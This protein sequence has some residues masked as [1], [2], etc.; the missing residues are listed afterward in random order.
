MTRLYT[1]ATPGSEILNFYARERVIAS[2]LTGERYPPNFEALER[3]PEPAFLFRPGADSLTPTLKVLGASQETEHVGGYDLIR[4]VR[5]M[6]RRYRQVPAAVLRGSASH[7]S[8]A[9]GRA[10]DRD[11]DSAWESVQPRTP[12]MWVEL[13]LGKPVN[14]GMV[15]LWNRGQDHG[16]Y[17]M[18]LRV[19]TS[20]DGTAWRDAVARSAMDYFYSSGP[21][22][23]PWEWGY[24][25]E[26]SFVPVAARRV[27]ISQYEDGGRFPWKIAEAYVYEDLGARPL[28]HT[29]EPD[30]LRRVAELG[31]D[32]VYADR[33]MSARIS[34]SSEGRVE[35]VTPFTAAI[36]AFYVK[37]KSRV[38]RWGERTGFVLEDGDAD[39][40]ERQIRDE[41]VHRLV[42]EDFGRW[43]LFHARG[44]GAAAAALENDPG[45]WW[46][47]LGA[48][49]TDP[50]GKSRYLASL[51]QTAYGDGRFDQAV[52]HS[53]KAV[54]AEACNADAR[55]VL[56]DALGKLGLE[57]EA[58][59]ESRTLVERCEPRVR[60]RS[61]SGTRLG[62]AP[63]CPAPS[64]RYTSG[65]ENGP[66]SEPAQGDA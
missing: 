41:G 9:M 48:V 7:E 42:R 20:L 56:I 43:V 34:E 22:V 16:Y 21:R 64:A 12:G 15:R 29:G 13:D 19:E 35:T 31:L 14:V 46:M 6:D 3:D 53:R 26:A 55:R 32:R 49:R 5:P 66:G 37:L 18:E 4:H 54:G 47:G 36:P 1:P 65:H 11:M 45:W 28:G 51:G 59:T 24:R 57:A 60:T 25:W 33:W 10:I 38:I 58:A 23:Y 44:S 61:S 27:R 8:Q 2:Q 52:E 40:F 39:E 63:G 30:V 17:A 50:R 62:D